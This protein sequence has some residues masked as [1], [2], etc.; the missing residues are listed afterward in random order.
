M[1]YLGHNEPF[2][3]S[4]VR[5]SS[6]FTVIEPGNFWNLT[7]A[8]L[9]KK[10]KMSVQPTPFDQEPNIIDGSKVNIMQGDAF[11]KPENNI[12]QR[13]NIDEVKR[14]Y[15]AILVYYN[16]GSGD[17]DLMERYLL[18]LQ[19]LYENPFMI[20]G[21]ETLNQAQTY[22]NGLEK[23]PAPAPAPTPTPEPVPAPE[24]SKTP[25]IPVDYHI[26]GRA[27]PGSG[28]QPTPEPEPEQKYRIDTEELYTAKTRA[29]QVNT[30]YMPPMQKQAF[31]TIKNRV[32]QLSAGQE[33]SE[34]RYNLFKD[35]YKYI[36]G[37]YN[38]QRM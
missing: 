9:A 37:V 31:M 13:V 4:D 26:P 2:G 1:S 36:I 34:Q 29:S 11:K 38:A 7:P 22:L 6:R 28:S 27:D 18:D 16:K 21:Q 32:D 12:T 33:V 35:D 25:D 14:V 17:Q 10:H 8:E 3:F 15:N 23:A 24:P 20:N 30:I 5:H 19:T